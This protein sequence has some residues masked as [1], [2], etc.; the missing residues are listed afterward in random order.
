MLI[1][2]CIDLIH[3]QSW[4]RKRSAEAVNYR[5][6]SRLLNASLHLYK[7]VCPSVRRL[8][9]W[10]VRPLVDRSVCGSV[11]LSINPSIHPSVHWSIR[12]SVPNPFFYSRN[13]FFPTCTMATMWSR[14]MHAH[15]HAHT[16]A[17][18]HTLTH[19]HKR[20]AHS[21]LKL[22]EIDTFKS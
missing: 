7:M 13:R 16:H 14:N 21:G 10:S 6:T 12:R 11:R 5:V 3:C 17:D 20:A 2:P 18:T 4:M 8:V 19:T 9:G 22:H 1:N 15:T